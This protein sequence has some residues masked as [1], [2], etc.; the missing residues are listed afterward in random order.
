MSVDSQSIFENTW[1]HKVNQIIMKQYG[2]LLGMQPSIL[3]IEERPPQYRI[4][5]ETGTTTF[6][7]HILYD[8]I[9]NR[10]ME[11]NITV[12][13][14][15]ESSSMTNIASNIDGTSATKVESGSFTTSSSSTSSGSSGTVS[16][17]GSG[18]AQS[19]SNSQR[20]TLTT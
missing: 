4:V 19:S 20:M 16:Q 15:G 10:I 17:S 2:N 18:S 9:L 8:F 11:G 6:T 1:I 7:F 3:S 5:Y 14:V 13:G 12:V